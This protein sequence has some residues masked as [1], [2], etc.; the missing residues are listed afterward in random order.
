MG[1]TRSSHQA[2]VRLAN[3]LPVCKDLRV[4]VSD[5]CIEKWQP[6]LDRLLKVHPIID[7]MIPRFADVYGPGP[8]KSFTLIKWPLRSREGRQPLKPDKYTYK[9]ITLTNCD[10]VWLILKVFLNMASSLTNV[11]LRAIEIV[12]SSYRHLK[13]RKWCLKSKG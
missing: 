3:L 6:G 1:F 10:K 8:F 4:R 2:S 12:I 13:K 9:A 5:D 11:N 7:L